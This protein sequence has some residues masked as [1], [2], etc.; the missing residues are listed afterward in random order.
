MAGFR[1]WQIFF[2]FLVHP[3]FSQSLKHI[4][5]IIYFL[6]FFFFFVR[7]FHLNVYFYFLFSAIFNY[8]IYKFIKKKKKTVIKYCTWIK[9]KV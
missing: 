2:L 1:Q 7:S 8:F 6:R 4:S 9:L 5:Y 3:Y